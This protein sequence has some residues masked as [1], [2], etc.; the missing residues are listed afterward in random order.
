MPSITRLQAAATVKRK[1]GQ[2]GGHLS[3]AGQGDEQTEGDFTDAVDYALRVCR[4]DAIT[5]ADTQSK[6]TAVLAAVEYYALQ[7]MLYHWTARPTQQQGAGASGL[8]LMVQTESTIAS[9]RMTVK[10]ALATLETALVAIGVRMD[11]QATALANI[12]EI[13]YDDDDTGPLVTGDHALPWFEE[14]YWPR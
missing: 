11:S 7:Q 12:V 9:L 3:A 5:D 13:A 8:H 10:A 14:G 4:F 6:I 2:L 1:L